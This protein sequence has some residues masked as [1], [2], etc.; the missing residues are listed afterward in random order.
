MREKS[1][2]AAAIEQLVNHRSSL[3]GTFGLSGDMRAVY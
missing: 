2:D 1:M 3:L